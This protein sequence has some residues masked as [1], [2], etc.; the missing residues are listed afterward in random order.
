MNLAFSLSN[1]RDLDSYSIEA[2]DY[3][4][5]KN[6]IFEKNARKLLN[7]ASLQK[8]L[9]AYVALKTLGA[10]YQFENKLYR[11][12]Y[13][14]KDHILQGNVYLYFGADPD[15]TGSDIEKFLIKLKSLKVQTINGDIVIDDS[16]FDEQLY[17]DGWII[18]NQRF[19]FA[20]P[21]SPIIINQNC[22]LVNLSANRENIHL[23]Y[24]KGIDPRIK[25]YAKI[26]NHED[27]YLDLIT[28]E[29]N[30]Y[31]LKGCSS[32]EEL[33]PRLSIAIR[34]PRIYLENIIKHY[35][36]KHNLKF[37]N[38]IYQKLNN[39]AVLVH[40]HKS[41]PLKLLIKPLLKDSNNLIAEIF[42][43]EFATVYK[44]N[45]GSWREAIKLYKDILMNDLN[46]QENEFNIADGSG[47]SL[48]N[49][50]SANTINNLLLHIYQNEQEIRKL[51]FD[52]LPQSGKD[53]TL[54][55]KLNNINKDYTIL[56]KTGTLDNTSSLSGYIIQDNNLRYIFSIIINNNLKNKELRFDEEERIL[57]DIIAIK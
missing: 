57:Q 51:I 39:K 18:E 42:M 13:I 46:L 49:L 43:K 55:D 3:K 31:Y 29:S 38:I 12:G 37:K 54:K 1:Q 52:A 28:N 50:I 24:N 7:P 17:P 15:F 53:G 20:A 48:K 41:R 27:C 45:P 23:T 16:R 47:L 56:A 14:T 36:K 21:T 40:S 22:F 33:P 9:T 19:C 35:A 25:N 11:S 2:I 26:L 10:N 32:V 6:V 34:N 30:E 4:N 8:I 44:K 5:G